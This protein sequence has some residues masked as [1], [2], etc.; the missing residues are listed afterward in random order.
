MSKKYSGISNVSLAMGVFLANDDYDHNDDPYTISATTLLKPI[1]QIILPPRIP[2]GDVFIDLISETAN[3]VG[4]AI[5]N[6]IEKAW[7]HSYASSMLKLG[8]PQKVIDSVVINPP[9]GTDL[10]DKIPFYLEQ[11]TAKKVGKWT[12][13]GKY[14]FIGDGMVQDF[15]KT[16]TYVYQRQTSGNKYI[17]QG[18]IYRWLDPKKITSDNMQIHYIF[19][20]WERSK[21]NDPSYPSTPILTQNFTLMGKQATEAMITAKLRDIEKY[22]DAPEEDL[23]LCTDE[24]LWRTEPSF[25]YYK[26]PK[27]TLRSTKNF[28]NKLEAY[29]RLSEDGN[30]GVVIEVP[31]Q[32]KA[33]KYC[34]AYSLC[35]QKDALIASGSLVITKE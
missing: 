14:D 4:S 17:Q 24:D 33:C 2:E 15:K 23:P 11:R 31:A 27:S 34:P 29:S 3:R 5:H 8:I 26:N 21:I 25:K 32:A 20:N 12:V 30:V 10:S 35:S 7:L 28:T 1:R 19:L 13:T 9:E 18:S 6:S 16:S 22:W